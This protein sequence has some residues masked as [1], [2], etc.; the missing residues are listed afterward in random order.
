M[1][2]VQLVSISTQTQLVG[3]I[4]NHMEFQTCDPKI[5]RAMVDRTPEFFPHLIKT[6]TAPVIKIID[7]GAEH[8]ICVKHKVWEYLYLIENPVT[9]KT[10]EKKIKSLSDQSDSW[11]SKAEAIA[12]RFV[13]FQNN[14][15]GASIMTRIKWVFTGVKF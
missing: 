14:T 8:Y 13:D 10:Q 3:D 4:R 15:F 9:A 2:E 5:E 12:M 1:K 7:K 11:Q 6:E